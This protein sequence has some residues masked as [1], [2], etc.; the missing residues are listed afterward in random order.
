M[1][2]DANT[3]KAALLEQKEL[4][5]DEVSER[6]KN[7]RRIAMSMVPY[8]GV[9]DRH[10]NNSRVV[11]GEARQ[12][13]VAYRAQNNDTKPLVPGQMQGRNLLGQNGLFDVDINDVDDNACH[14]SCIIDFA[15]SYRTLGFYDRDIS[16]S[17]QIFCV[18]DLQRL[19]PNQLT[20]FYRDMQKAFVRFGF[21]NFDENL[22]NDVMLASE[23]NT[24]IL[25]ADNFNLTAGGWAGVPQSRFTIWHAQQWKEEIINRMLSKGWDVPMDWQFTIEIP[26]EDW[27]DAVAKDQAVR[28]PSGTQYIL[29]YLEDAEGPMRGRQSA[30]YGG[31]KAY[32]TREPIRGYFLPTGGGATRFVR[33]Y[34]WMNVEDDIGGLRSVNNPDY[35]REN[36]TV[37][38]VTYPMVTLIPHIDPRSFQRWN[39][40][41]PVKPMG[42]A[43]MSVNW[44][45]NVIDGAYIDCNDDNDKFKLHGRHE[46]RFRATDPEVS[47]FMAYRHSRRA[48][49]TLAVSEG[50]PLSTPATTALPQTIGQCNPDDCS[51]LSCASCGQVPDQNLQCVDPDTA[52]AGVLALRPGGTTNNVVFLGSA[53]T[54]PMTVERTGDP[55]SAATVN[56][57]ITAGTATAGTDFTAATGTLEWAAGDTQPKTFNVAI[58]ATF[59]EAVAGTPDTVNV[60]ISSP[61][62]DTLGNATSTLRVGLPA[63]F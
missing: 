57:A 41:K 36:I 2:C 23:A 11:T 13:P 16:L 48:G 4:I 25:A 14:G 60:A 33:V 35:N 32:F 31:I 46:Y 52:P 45:V 53:F 7:S 55:S 39:L 54:V 56:Y 34:N 20:A 49:Y 29:K 3:T 26:V 40:S 10:V 28:N 30:T 37:G 22:L 27:I 9:V 43:N 61:T 12:A 1:A 38:G 21:D 5:T 62:G 63:S 51:T 59:A 18:R 8:K 44:D 42:G 6:M 19:K 24:S 58:L 15:N 50:A 47:G 17:T